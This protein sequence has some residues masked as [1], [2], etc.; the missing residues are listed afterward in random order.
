MEQLER[1]DEAVKRYQE[2]LQRNQKYFG[3]TGTEQASEEW[4]FP[5][6]TNTATATKTVAR[7][8]N[9]DPRPPS[10]EKVWKRRF[11]RKTSR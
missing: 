5:G 1:R 2:F 6:K 4:D 9:F 11:S 7:E 8:T 10:G 3:D